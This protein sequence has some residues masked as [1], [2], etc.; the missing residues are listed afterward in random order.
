MTDEAVVRRARSGDVDAYDSIIAAR[1]DHLY[2]VARLILRDYDRAEDAVQE[3]LV[4]SWRD[5]PRLRNASRFDAWLDR[6][7][8]HSVVDE[9]RRTRRVLT[10]L[11]NLR[12]EGTDADG[13]ASL[14]DRDELSRAFERLSTEHRTVVVLHYYLGLTA[15]EAAAVIG[16]PVGTAKSRLHYAAESLRA[17]LDADARAMSAGRVPA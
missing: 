12:A 6:I 8:M 17:V 15:E 16:I 11:P 10:A 13:E 14:A 2:R 5:L 7:L 3:A 1:V 9:A 4:R